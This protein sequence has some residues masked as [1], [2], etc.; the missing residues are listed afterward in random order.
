MS[1]DNNPVPASVRRSRQP[2]KTSKWT[3]VLVVLMFL[4][5]CFSYYAYQIVY[6]PNV[7]VKGDPVYVLIPKGATYEQAMDSVEGIGEHY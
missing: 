4:F 3:Y 2:K 5:V 1:E 6:T 7:E